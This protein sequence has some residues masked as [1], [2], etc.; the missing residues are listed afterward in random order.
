MAAN[1]ILAIFVC[2][3]VMCGLAALFATMEAIGIWLIHRK[4]R[5][6]HE[7]DRKNRKDVA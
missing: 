4:Y 2:V 5:K 7:N 6:M 3:L 1:A